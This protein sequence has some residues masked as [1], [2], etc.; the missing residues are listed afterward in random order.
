MA[1]CYVDDIN[2][3]E[4]VV[5]IKDITNPVNYMTVFP[6]PSSNRTNVEFSLATSEKAAFGVYDLIG[7][8]ILSIDETNYSAGSHM[9]V[10]NDNDLSQGIYFLKATISDQKFTQK[11]IIVK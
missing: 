7:N 4:G 6:N 2:I 5:G 8:K 11:L 9:V 3:A 1:N 10:F